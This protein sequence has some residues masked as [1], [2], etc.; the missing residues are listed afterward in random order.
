MSIKLEGEEWQVWSYKKQRSGS[1]I[2]ALLVDVKVTNTVCL[3]PSPWYFEVL[4]NHFI[5]FT[6]PL[7]ILQIQSHLLLA[8]FSVKLL[9]F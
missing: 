1:I 8:F 2:C 6:I 7:T 4:R 5:L 9:L 3:L